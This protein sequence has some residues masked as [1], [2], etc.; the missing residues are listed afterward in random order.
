MKITDLFIRRPILALV[1]NVLILLMGMAALFKVSVRQFPLVENATITITTS[2]PGGTAETMQGFVTTP[3]TQAIATASGIEYLKSESTPGLSVITVQLALNANSNVAMTEIMAKINEVK[4]RLP[5]EVTDPVIQKMSNDPT[6]LTYIAF[7]SNE[8]RPAQITDYLIRTVQPMLSAIPGVSQV[9]L[10]GGQTL[11]MRVWLDP[12]R[13]AAYNLSAE[14]VSDAIQRNNFLAAPGQTSNSFQVN[15]IRAETDLTSVDEFR[16]LVVR[17]DGNAQVRLRDIAE[18]ELGSQNYNQMGISDDKRPDHAA[19][20]LAVYATPAGNPLEIVRAVRALMPEIERNLPPT[21]RARISFDVAL[22]VQAAIDEVRKTLV[23]SMAIV[24]LLIFLFL[25]S[26]RSVMIPVVTIPLSLVGTVGLMYLF[27][28]SVNL[29]TLLAMVMAIGLVVDDAIVVVENVHRHMEEGLSPKDAALQGAREIVGPVIAMTLTLAA[30]YAP[31]GVMG[32][33]TGALFREFA[34]TLA[35]AVIV[36]G[37]IALTLSPT[38]CAVFLKRESLSGPFAHAVDQFFSRV[39]EGYARRLRGSLNYRPVTLLLVVSV[40]ASLWFMYQGSATELAPQEDQGVILTVFKGP[41]GA[42]LEYTRAYMG[43]M[44]KMLGDLPETADRFGVNGSTG[45]FAAFGGALF[46]PWDER[47]RSTQDLLPIVQ[48]ELSKV[49]G[50]TAFAFL[51]PPLP[52]STGGLPVQLAIKTAA[53]YTDLYN[54]VEKLKTAARESGMFLLTDSDLAFDNPAVRIVIDRAKA[55]ALGIDMQKVGDTLTLLVGGNYVNRLSLQGRSYDVIMQVP[56]SYRFNPENLSQYYV[57]TKGG[58]QIPLSTIATVKREIE[59]NALTQ[60]A[61]LNS[62]TM[63][64]LPAP[65]VTMGAAVAFL[66]AKAKE[67]LPEGYSYDWLSDARQYV[68]EG[69]RLVTTFAIA[70]VV[71]FLVLAAQFNSLRDPLIILIT[72]PLSVFGALIPVFLGFVTLNI[73]TQIGLVTLIGL[74]SKHGILMV[75]FANRLQVENQLDR[76]SAIV[77]AA[78]VR[79]RP[80]LM[81]TAAMVVGLVPLVVASGAGASARY[82]IGLVIVCGMSVGTLFTLFVL[83]VFYTLLAHNHTHDATESVPVPV[84]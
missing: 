53:P 28:F 84:V 75:E 45:L 52:G 14:Q 4:Y 59:P 6:A 65:G 67:I 41:R 27:G 37:V 68:Q 24:V 43:S 22:F 69:S 58:G 19:T 44:Q 3:I 49:E 50:G 18:V 8:L 36:S 38:M 70:V 56:R 66:Q 10:A 73:Y 80:I 51:L 54:N 77:R 81:T 16:D 26:F 48:G 72:V 40:L 35:G 76:V 33:L 39:A 46:K 34:L 55:N 60:F 83:P 30:V 23:E 21:V 11:A 13:M 25:G 63:Q 64:L 78:Q 47:K 15:S 31:I 5:R 79:L 42:S 29:L 12:V 71:I 2:Y 1:V 17:A 57:P 32:G 74:I 9:E 7:S 82:N 61:Q 62:A 20:H